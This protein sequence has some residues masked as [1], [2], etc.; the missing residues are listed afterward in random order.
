MKKNL[1]H[2]G[3]EYCFS[4]LSSGDGKFRVIQIFKGIRGYIPIS[5]LFKREAEAQ[6]LVHEMN[7]EIGVN[8]KERLQIEL[9]TLGGADESKN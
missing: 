1:S 2:D 9:S 3:I 8:Q 6:L 5:K 7:E 4:Y